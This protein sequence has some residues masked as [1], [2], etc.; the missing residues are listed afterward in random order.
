MKALK[1]GKAPGLDNINAELIKNVK[2]PLLENFK[3]L[4]N[5]ILERGYYPVRWN[6]GIIHSIHK[7]GD[8]NDP[9]NYRGITLSL[10][11]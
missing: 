2:G 9:N 4:F 5:K 10:F 11:K 8:P 6:Q 1:T 7:G 3:I